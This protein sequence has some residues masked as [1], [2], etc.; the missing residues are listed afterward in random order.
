M[1]LGFLMDGPASL[2]T[3]MIGIRIAPH[4][5]TPYLSTSVASFWGK[6]WNLTASNSLRTIIYDTIQ[7]GQPLNSLQVPPAPSH[8]DAY[9][10]APTCKPLQT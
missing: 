7:D 9:S 8:C 2:A 6:R 1:F 5:D 10:L 4:F 3:S